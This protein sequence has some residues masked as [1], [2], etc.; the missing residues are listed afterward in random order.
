MILYYLLLC[1][2]RDMAPFHKCKNQELAGEDKGSRPSSREGFTGIRG[3]LRNG[4][5]FPRYLVTTSD[6]QAGSEG[7]R[8]GPWSDKICSQKEVGPGTAEPGEADLGPRVGR[9]GLT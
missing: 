9:A 8:S 6:C 3:K 2:I 4:E 5:K 7:K 1:M